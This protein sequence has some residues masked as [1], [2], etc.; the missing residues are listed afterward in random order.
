[1]GVP[2]VHHCAKPHAVSSV[3]RCVVIVQYMALAGHALG[4]QKMRLKR[5]QLWGQQVS[6]TL[7]V[8]RGLLSLLRII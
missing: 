8:P 3:E 5:Q 2:S 6:Q 7:S 4:V 1:M